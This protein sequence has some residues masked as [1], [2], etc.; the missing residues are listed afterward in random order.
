MLCC[1]MLCV[2]VRLPMPPYSRFSLSL[3]FFLLC[4][5]LKYSWPT[6]FSWFFCVRNQK[7]VR[8]KHGDSGSIYIQIY[9]FFCRFSRYWIFFSSLFSRLGD[10]SRRYQYTFIVWLSLS[11][12]VDME[13]KKREKE[14]AMNL[15][16]RAEQINERKEMNSA[17]IT[18]YCANYRETN[19]Y[20]V[21]A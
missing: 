12:V 10:N 4:H 6:A 7:K 5:F 3:F 9:A 18:I 17:T 16:F 21:H 19:A 20:L 2:C 11:P 13:E 14:S 1:V 15:T 8:R